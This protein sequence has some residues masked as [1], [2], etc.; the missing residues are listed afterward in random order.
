MRISQSRRVVLLLFMLFC[1]FG[2]F[3]SSFFVSTRARLLLL[4]CGSIL[5]F[6]SCSSA[7]NGNMRS[8]ASFSR[9]T[10]TRFINL[11]ILVVCVCFV[12]PFSVCLIP[13]GFPSLHFRCLSQYRNNTT[14][15]KQGTRILMAGC[16]CSTQIQNHIHLK[17]RTKLP[18]FFLLLSKFNVDDAIVFLNAAAYLHF[19]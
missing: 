19:I 13:V 15:S 3:Y 7:L 12:L 14:F 18:I 5:A 4:I 2:G 6:K 16:I 10:C 8:Q 1:S 9:Q 17:Q 11:F